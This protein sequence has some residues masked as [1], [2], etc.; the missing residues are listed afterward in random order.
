MFGD[1][2]LVEYDL[3]LGLAQMF[4]HRPDVASDLWVDRAEINELRERTLVER[5]KQDCYGFERRIRP[6]IGIIR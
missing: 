5:E 6:K 3:F 2:E 1:M 4:A